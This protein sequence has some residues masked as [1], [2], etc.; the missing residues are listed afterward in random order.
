MSHASV[1][2]IARRTAKGEASLI[3]ALFCVSYSPVLPI[4]KDNLVSARR[5]ALG[6]R[7][8]RVD[9]LYDWAE[10]RHRLQRRPTIRPRPH[11]LKGVGGLQDEIVAMSRADDLQTDRESG[12][13]ETCAHGGGG[14]PGQIEGNG[15]RRDSGH[16]RAFAFDLFRERAGRG[17]RIVWD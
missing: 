15:E 6:T 16:R 10:K 14:V 13:G 4:T 8:S 11:L 3:S 1:I 2:R 5:A 12:A 17:W 7:V 9:H